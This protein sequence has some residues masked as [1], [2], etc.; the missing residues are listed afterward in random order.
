MV[1]VL[2]EELRLSIL[3]AAEEEFMQHGYAQSSVKRI[4]QQV[5]VS[6]GNL[7]RYYDGKEALFDAVVEPA[8]HELERLMRNPEPRPQQTEPMFEQ[9]VLALTD[10][11][12]AYRRPLLILIDGSKGTTRE[13]AVHALFEQMAGNVI[14]HMQA[15]NAK[16]GREVFAEQAAWPVA[17]AFLQGY[18]EVIRRHAER[19]ERRAMVRQYV[20]FWYEGLRAFLYR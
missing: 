16:A 4:A 1:Q 10:L 13:E 3:S 11:S 14:S 20:S 8:F 9:I 19:E 17:V 12:E 7:Y 2:K 5:G 18:F 15:Y 6:V